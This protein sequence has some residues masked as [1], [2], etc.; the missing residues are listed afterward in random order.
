[1]RVCHLGVEI[2]PGPGGSF[3]GGLVKNVATVAREQVARGHEVDVFTSDVAGSVPDGLD[4]PYGRIHRIKTVGGYA[5]AT[6]VASFM[7]RAASA[8]K[9]EYRRAPFDVLHLHSA[10]AFLSGIG[11]SLRNLPVAK[12]FSLYSPNF[13]VLSGHDCNGFASAAGRPLASRFLNEFDRLVVPS[14]NLRRRLEAHGVGDGRVVRVPPA[15]SPAMLDSLPSAEDARASLGVPEDTRIVLYLGNYSKWKGIEELLK[16]VS[17]LRRDFPD[18]VLLAAWGE[19]YQWSGN[20]RRQVLARIQELGL[21]GRV[22][23]EGILSD[24]RPV[25]RAADFLVSPFQCTCKVLDYPLSILE[26]MAC[27]RPVVS[28]LVGGI[29]E[30]IGQGD[31]GLVV[32]PRDAA[33]LG[34]AMRTLLDDGP[35]ASEMGRRGAAWARKGFRP[36]DVVE[37][38]DSTYTGALSVAG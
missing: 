11:R 38:L 4:S 14:E 36:S 28:T 20:R 30:L 5:S 35:G 25:L 33:S 7:I 18:V 21:G 1:M 24:V 26:A 34:R 13:K 31:R 19:P 15:L 6:F 2:V 10:Y 22:R 32:E 29:P 3:V 27:E 8:I 37:A 9:R 17:E 16:A 12:V 23:H